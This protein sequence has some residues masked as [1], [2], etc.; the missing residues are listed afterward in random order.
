MAE[1]LYESTVLV[2]CMKVQD[3]HPVDGLDTPDEE[4]SAEDVIRM[5]VDSLQ[6][7]DEP[8]KD[9]GIETAYNF[10]SPSNRSNTGPLRKFKR[11]VKNR[12]Y[13]DMIDYS[14]SSYVPIERDGNTAKQEVVLIQDDGTET[15]YEFVVSLQSEGEFEDCW[16][17]D[18]VRLLERNA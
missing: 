16:M 8:W 4:Y 6:E 11:M 7:N 14:R 3:D 17:T 9:A 2:L 12:M 13:S 10:A 18:A 1:K 15:R 5:Q